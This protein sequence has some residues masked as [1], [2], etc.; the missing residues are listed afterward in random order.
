MGKLEKFLLGDTLC[1][2]VICLAG[3][4]TIID[5]LAVLIVIRVVVE[6]TYIGR[7][8]YLLSLSDR[9]YQNHFFYLNRLEFFLLKRNELRDIVAVPFSMVI[10]GDHLRLICM[11][12]NY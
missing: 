7:G 4:I 3:I 5:F 2:C 10:H 8:Q 11:K 12:C 9:K 6:N 1:V